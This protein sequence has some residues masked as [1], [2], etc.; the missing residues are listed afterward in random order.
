MALKGLKRDTAFVVDPATSVEFISFDGGVYSSTRQLAQFIYNVYVDEAAYDAG[1]PPKLQ[2]TLTTSNLMPG[3]PPVQIDLDNLT[4][5]LSTDS[6]ELF[7]TIR[8]DTAYTVFENIDP[9]AVPPVFIQE[10]MK[11]W[12]ITITDA[13]VGAFLNETWT[14]VQNGV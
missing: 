2:I 12:N 4:V 10:S 14:D 3:F 5:N 1:H 11:P 7:K 13:T 9:N 6:L 8:E